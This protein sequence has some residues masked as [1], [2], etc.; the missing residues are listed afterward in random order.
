MIVHYAVNQI[1]NVKLLGRGSQL[2]RDVPQDRIFE[3][4][5]GHLVAARLPSSGRRSTAVITINDISIADRLRTHEPVAGGAG[6]A[7]F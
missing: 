2:L 3:V 1:P 5:C 6:D 4:L 7:V